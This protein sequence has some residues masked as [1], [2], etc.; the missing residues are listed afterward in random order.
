[1]M[2]SYTE[3]DLESIGQK[4]G[5]FSKT[6]G[7]VICRC[8]AHDDAKASLSLSIGN[9]DGHIGKLLWRCHAGC[10]QEAVLAGLKRA[11][12]LLNGDARP[13]EPQHNARSRSRI[14]AT[15][16][17]TDEHG[18]LLYEKLRYDPK[19]F[20]QR[21][22]RRQQRLGLEARRYPPRPLPPARSARGR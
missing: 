16:A 20:R 12:V 2:H 22:P 9:G 1:M 18:E 21:R 5:G 4:L 17:Y 15:Y 6:S 10:S 11:G 8:P 7:G 3:R 14:V 19:D 13:A